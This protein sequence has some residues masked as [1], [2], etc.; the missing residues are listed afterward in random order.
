MILWHSVNL[1]DLITWQPN[2]F[3]H[4]C[5]NS[6]KYCSWLTDAFFSSSSIIPTQQQLQDIYEE[7]LRQREASQFFPDSAARAQFL[8]DERIA[9]ML[10][11]EEFMSELRRDQEF[12][13]A[14]EM[15]QQVRKSLLL[16]QTQLT[17]QP[18]PCLWCWKQK[19]LGRSHVA[20][21]LVVRL[22]RVSSI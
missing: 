22:S 18:W 12:M 14:L 13:S 15:E 17:K 9:L 6:I 19:G 5:K 16:I 2:D 10:Q 11:N 7:N 4:K 1:M 3:N 8:E 21:G 20:A